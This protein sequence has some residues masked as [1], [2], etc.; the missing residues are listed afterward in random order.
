[1]QLIE[2]MELCTTLSNRVLDLENV[3]DAQALE[4]Q[5]LKK[6][7]KRLEK[8]RKSRTPQLK[9]R[10]FKV[11][12][13]SSIE[14][15]L[16]DQEDAS[17]Q[18]RN[19]QDEEFLFIQEDAETQGSAPVTIVGV[20]VSTAKPSTPQT[21][22]TTL[23]KDEDLTIA[24]AFMK[25]RSVKSKEKSKEKGVSNTR[26]TRGVIMKEA[27]ETASRPM[28]PP[29][30]Q[31]DPKDKGKCIMQEPKKP[32]KVKGKDQ[33]A[34][35]GEVARRLEAQMQAGFEKEERVARQ[36]EQEANLISWDNTQVM[37][38]ADYEKKHFAK[39]RAEEIRIKP[40][41]KAQKRNQM[42]TYL[43]NMANYKH[44]VL[45][46]SGKKAKSSRK[47]AVSKKRT[48]EEFDQESSKRQNSSES[49]ELAKEPRDKEAD[50][51]SQEELQQMMITA[52]ESIKRSSEL[53]I[54]LRE[55]NRHLH[56]DREGVFIV[57]RNSYIDAGSKALGGSR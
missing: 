25:M 38:E 23:I 7:V 2:L 13:E 55:R 28:V 43:K 37:M 50:E 32:M 47:E 53:E 24:Q 56:A 54:I 6:R 34:L 16:V 36:R 1:M 18:G 19:D 39:L 20:S 4:I 22:T 21:I 12:I 5:K 26:L 9:R 3:K 44:K 17:N 15:S 35:D 29:Q 14:K 33:I 11:M 52:L 42:C 27:S 48:E 46:G 8:K 41:T 45:E 31:L 51:L 49:S 30:Q 10:L 57:K 40:L